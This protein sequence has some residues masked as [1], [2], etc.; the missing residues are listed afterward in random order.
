[1]NPAKLFALQ[2]TRVPSFGGVSG[3]VPAMTPDL[4]A[5][6]CRGMD[7]RHYL[8]ARLKWGLDREAGRELEKYLWTEAMEVLHKRHKWSIKKYSGKKINSYYRPHMIRDMARLAVLEMGETHKL[9]DTLR[10]GILDID[11]SNYSRKW[12]AIYSNIWDELN[13]WTNE[14]HRHVKKMQAND[15]I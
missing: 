1:M 14:A 12:K 8:A 3:G 7:Q 2:T 5:L 11:K 4:A 6:Y 9:N 13:E 15:E 10:A